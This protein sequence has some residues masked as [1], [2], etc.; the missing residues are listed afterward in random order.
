MTIVAIRTDK[1]QAELYI[2]QEDTTLAQIKWTA[3]R[4]LLETIHKKLN[5]L[6][7]KENLR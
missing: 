3:H 2:L 5:S 6:L 7:I 1:P 4:Q